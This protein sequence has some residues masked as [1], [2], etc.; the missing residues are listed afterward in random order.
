MQIYKNLSV[1]SKQENTDHLDQT[2]DPSI[3]QNEKTAEGENEKLVVEEH[4]DDESIVGARGANFQD[5]NAELKI[6]QLGDVS[7]ELMEENIVTEDQYIEGSSTEASS[8]AGNIV[9][10]GEIADEEKAQS[11]DSRKYITEDDHVI[12]TPTEASFEKIVEINV[13]DVKVTEKLPEEVRSI[14]NLA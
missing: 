13:N 8:I 3:D 7:P 2:I 10:E 9:S 6:T 1:V 14:T 4:P 5:D 12:G 11:E